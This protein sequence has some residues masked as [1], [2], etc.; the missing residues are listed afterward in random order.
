MYALASEAS[1]PQRVWPW[2]ESLV[3]CCSVL[4]LAA[5]AAPM[6]LSPLRK[7]QL[8]VPPGTLLLQLTSEDQVWVSLESRRWERKKGW[9]APSF[10]LLLNFFLFKHLSQCIILSPQLTK[11]FSRMEI[12]VF[13]PISLEIMA[14]LWIFTRWVHRLLNGWRLDYEKSF[15]QRLFPAS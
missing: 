12:C 13:Y 6:Q 10:V 3:S 2:G 8:Y 4:L 7:T 9:V 5:S 11:Y 1:P 15:P 14:S